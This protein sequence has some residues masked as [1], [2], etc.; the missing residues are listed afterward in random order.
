MRLSAK[1]RK[2]KARAIAKQNFTRS[3]TDGE[4]LYRQVAQSIGQQIRSGK[5]KPGERLPSMDDL[6]E[7]Y[8][9]TKITVRRALLELKSEGLLYTRPAQ[10]TYVA[11]ALPADRVQRKSQ[12]LTVG[13]VSHVLLPENPGPYHSEILA[14]LRVEIGKLKGNLVVLPRPETG[15]GDISEQMRHSNLDAVVYLGAFDSDSL[16]RM[17]RNGPP[18]VL[19]DFLVRGLHVDSILVDNIGGGEIA[20]D[21]L[22]S[23]GHKQIAVILGDSEGNVTKDRLMGVH[24]ALDRAGIPAASAR[25][26]HGDFTVDAGLKA[27]SELLKADPLPTAVFCMNDEMAVGALQA[28]QR[29]SS[30]G[31]P[32]DI[33]LIGFDDIV[34]GTTTHPRLTT[35]RVDKRLMGRLTMER[36]MAVLED[37][38][39]TVTTT[40]IGTELVI[41]ESTAPPTVRTPPPAI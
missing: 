19:V 28:I 40:T 6:A 25:M 4:H 26:I 5:L 16:R 30:L 11:D 13:V 17:V 39:H 18:A 12:V 14:S 24:S 7:V 22:T 1:S 10:G 21:H 8:G 36:V 33:S 3:R 29:E 32:R 41:R 37:R 15:E 9:V 27:M 20:I 38:S 31:V 34:W 23:L 2:A 35:V